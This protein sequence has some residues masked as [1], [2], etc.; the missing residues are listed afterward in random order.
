MGLL[1]CQVEH[2]PDSHY[3]LLPG[4]G[5]NNFKA[6]LKSQQIQM[7]NAVHGTSL[8]FLEGAVL[9]CINALCKVPMLTRVQS[10]AEKGERSM[11]EGQ[12]V[13]ESRTSHL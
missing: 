11:I 6:G 13:G 9:S 10:S 4:S 1:G 3:Q 12:L 5:H 8:A 7:T 2:F